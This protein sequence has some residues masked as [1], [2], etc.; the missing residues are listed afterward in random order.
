ML[1]TSSSFA[2]QQPHY[3][4]NLRYFS[5]AAQVQSFVLA[6]DLQF[7]SHSESNR[8][9]IKTREGAMWLTAPVLTK[10]KPGQLI[11][12]VQI[13]NTTNWRMKHWK[14]L[15]C[16]YGGAP[17]FEKYAEGL[18]KI[19]QREWKHLVD[20]N[21]AAFELVHRALH[22]HCSWQRSSAWE[23]TA[24]GSQRVV[25]MGRRLHAQQY[26][27]EPE[28]AK[29]L[30]AEKFKEAGIA[31]I[32]GAGV[33]HEYHQQY[34]AFVPNLSVLDL[35]FNEGEEAEKFLGVAALQ[36]AFD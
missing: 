26:L 20:L 3:F 28:N 8:T 6:D 34:G 36:S 27:T 5:K 19:F 9:R 31:L 10:G 7:T 17:Y 30:Q 32:L 33:E 16:H 14:T 15:R 2:A 24:G 35:L 12:D 13:D 22:L 1:L 29:F 23:I 18:E 21:L 25:E 11:K 4:P